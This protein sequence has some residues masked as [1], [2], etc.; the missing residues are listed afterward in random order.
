M[1][2]WDSI[3]QDI[4]ESHILVKLFITVRKHTHSF[5]NSLVINLIFYSPENIKEEP[6]P[7]TPAVCVT[8]HKDSDFKEIQSEIRKYL[9][10]QENGQELIKLRTKNGILVPLSYILAGSSENDPYIIEVLRLYQHALANGTIPQV[11]KDTVKHRFEN[12]EKRVQ[13]LEATIPDLKSLRMSNIER[14]AEQLNYK[15]HFLNRRIDDLAPEDWKEKLQ[16]S[17]KSLSPIRA[18]N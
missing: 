5:F 1:K 8:L 15:L 4:I 17:G 14:V 7:S 18:T 12:L 9:G 10:L 6:L 11:V 13:H 3:N 2:F 16:S